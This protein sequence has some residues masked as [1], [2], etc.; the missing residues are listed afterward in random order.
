MTAT[1]EH[2]TAAHAP[3]PGLVLPRSLVSRA[4]FLDGLTC[5]WV[6]TEVGPVG[7]G[8]WGGSGGD[9]PG[10]FKFGW[11]EFGGETALG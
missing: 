2:E 5:Q 11:W 1:A 6:E 7:S 8:L 4:H 3:A 10:E 9:E